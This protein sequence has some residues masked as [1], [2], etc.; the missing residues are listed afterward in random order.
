V[1]DETAPISFPCS[2][3][4][5]LVEGPFLCVIIKHLHSHAA[6]QRIGL[7]RR[8]RPTSR[9]VWSVRRSNFFSLSRVEEGVV[10]CGVV[11]AAA[12]IVVSISDDC[13]GSHPGWNPGLPCVCYNCRSLSHEGGRL[14]A[15]RRVARCCCFTEPAKPC[16]AE[17]SLSLWNFEVALCE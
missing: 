8:R 17:L 4:R 16:V 9:P 3:P 1:G 15:A 7:Q 14:P 12:A 13:R 2:R 5:S 11:H 6:K 10:W